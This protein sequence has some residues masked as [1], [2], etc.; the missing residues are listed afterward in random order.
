MI[1]AY[2]DNNATTQ[3]FAEVLEARR[4]Y[5]EELYFN[6]SSTAGDLLGA[7][8]PFGDAQRA[9]REL[10]GSTDTADRIILTSGATEANAWAFHQVPPGEGKVVI[11]ATEHSS[12]LA[13]CERRSD[14]HAVSVDQNGLIDL[15]ALAAHLGDETRLVSVQLAN[16]ETG[17]V[18][19]LVAIG[20]C[21]EQRAPRAILH[22]DA[23]QAV[24]RI[25]ID[26]NGDLARVDLLSFS[27][28]KFHGP[29]GLGGLFIRGGMPIA[30]L[31]QG[32]QQDG[33]RGGTLNSPG[34]AGLAVAARMARDN[35]DLM[36]F[37][38]ALRNRLED[39]L[40]AL[41]PSARFHGAGADRLPNTCCVS[42]PGCDAE[43]FVEQLAMRGVCVAAGSA[44]TAGASAPSHVLV[45]MGVPR[46][47]IFGALRFSLSVKTTADEID[48]AVASLEEIAGQFA[49]G[50]PADG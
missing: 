21:I 9:M 14:S 41:W 40:Q 26:L 35:L 24:G 18:Q 48:A 28:H 12:I 31:I 43:E 29:K 44:C 37:V 46:D 22:C 33:A 47:E 39:R 7:S 15:N 2:L 32:T 50:E 3:P 19:P 17:V 36:P 8:R 30:P 13:A 4:I 5:D 1:R 6:A 42:L 11:S 38:A 10:L 16:N 45:A 27:A 25:P 23:T 49:I 20:E 34:A